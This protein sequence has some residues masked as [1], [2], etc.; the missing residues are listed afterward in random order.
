VTSLGCD[1]AQGF[2]IARPMRADLAGQSLRGPRREARRFAA[3]GRVERP[4]SVAAAA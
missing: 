2:Y 3:A 1:G 4:A